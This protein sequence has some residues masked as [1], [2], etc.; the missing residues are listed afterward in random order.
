MFATTLL[1]ATLV[2]PAS[3]EVPAPDVRDTVK[4]GLKWLA[5]K[6]NKDGTWS[7]N[8]LTVNVTAYAG[9]ALLMEGS[10]LKEGR[11]AANLRRAVAWFEKIAQPDGRLVPA[12][13]PSERNRYMQS[14]AAALLFLAS[15][16]DTDDDEARRKRLGKILEN[17]VRFAIDGQTKRGGWGFVSATPG[18][19]NDDTQ[20]TAFMIQSLV[21]AE[22]AGIKVPREVFDRATQYLVD[23]TAEDGGMPYTLVRGATRQV[24]D[25][26]SLQ[27]SAATAAVTASGR[28]PAVLTKW[29]GYSKRST[30]SLQ[31]PG[32][33]A[34]LA[35]SNVF[36]LQQH[37]AAARVALSLGETGHRGL[38]ADV[39]ETDLFRWSPYREQLFKALKGTQLTDGSW[40]DTGRGIGPVYATS[41]ALIILQLDNNYL[42]AFS[43]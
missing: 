28:K 14:Q 6:Q 42:P 17:A 13:D 7:G 3:P 41:L 39:R 34:R 4:N 30:A 23:A 36:A 24:G 33:P 38:D 26:Q 35:V 12:D 37:L 9:L 5:E 19:E 1:A 27:T 20:G 31:A 25:G 22:K 11:Y 18:S 21:V 29:I 2:T 8:G 10:T 32:Q 43:K 15:A 16:Y 40:T